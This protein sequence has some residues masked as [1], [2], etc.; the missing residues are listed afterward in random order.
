VLTSS[1]RRLLLAVAFPDYSEST[2]MGRWPEAGGGAAPCRVRTRFS[3][4]PVGERSEPARDLA[5]VR[6]RLDLGRRHAARVLAAHPS[7]DV[8]R[9]IAICQRYEGDAR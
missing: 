9:Y 1:L 3:A 4:S 7:G 5:R 6:H 8:L 2:P